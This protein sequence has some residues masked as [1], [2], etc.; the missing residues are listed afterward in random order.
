[1]IAELSRPFGKS[2]KTSNAPALSTPKP[3]RKWRVRV[4][5]LT[6]P[7]V[8]ADR[9]GEFTTIEAEDGHP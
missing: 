5:D 9:V 7:Q 4:W 3:K 6:T 1:M 2:Q 8:K